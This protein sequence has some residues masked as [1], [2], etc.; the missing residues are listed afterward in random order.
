MRSIK[1]WW[2]IFALI[3]CTIPAFGQNSELTGA[4]SD[5]SGARI[6]SASVAFR[7]EGTNTTQRFQTNQA[8][9]Y[10]AAVAPGTYSIEI[11]A[12]GFKTVTR[13][14]VKLDVA[15]KATLDFSLTAGAEDQ[16]VTV[17]A[18]APILQTSSSVGNLISGAEIARLPVNGRNYTTLELLAPGVGD[19]SKSQN[20]GTISGTNLYSINGQR[21]QDHNYLLD[22]IEN[23]FFHKSSPGGSPPL[24]AI[25]EFQLATNNSAEYGRSAGAA[26]SLVSK[27]G[28][29]NFHGSLYEYLRN[30]A[31]DANNY[32]ANHEGLGRTPLHL[33]NF[34]VAVD[35]PLLG[36]NKLRGLHNTF[37]FL[38]YDGLRESQSNPI[39]STV[40][41][42][43]E[44]NGNFS[45][46]GASIYDPTTST[47][48][49]SG[50]VIR[51]KFANNMI[52]ASMIDPVATAYLKLVPLPNRSGITNNYVNTQPKTNSHD[53]WLGRVDYAVNDRNNVFFRVYDQ[54]V[55]QTSPQTFEDFSEVTQFNVINLGLGWTSQLSKDSVLQV[56]LGWDLPEGPDFT[57]NTL[58]VTG[59]QFLTQNNVQ[60]F[61][62]GTLYDFIPSISASGDF[63]ISESGGTSKDEVYQIS[64][65]YERQ[66]GRSDWKFGVSIVPRK[67][68]HASSSSLTGQASFTQGLTNSANDSKSGSS[69]ASFL[70]GYPSSVQR[71]QGN[72]VGNARQLYTAYYAQFHRR[73][74]D[75]LTLDA[76]VRYEFFP[77]I[78]DRDNRFG[79]LWVHT[80]P[81]TGAPVGTLLWAGV[82]PLPDQVTGVV[83]D[84][85]NRAG[86]GR[87]LQVTDYN[88]WAPRIGLAYSPR[89][90]WVIRA[91]AGVYYNTTFF[92]ESQDKSGFYPYNSQQNFTTN[93]SLLP[94]L[95]IE[96]AG[97]SYTNTAGIGG[98]AQ[99][100]NNRTPY[101]W[102]YN[103]FI[104]KALP[105]SITAKIGYVGSQNRKQIGYTYFNT[106]P[107]P[108]PGAVQPRRY[109][110]DY[111]DINKG[112]NAFSSNYNALQMQLRKRYTSGLEFSANYTYSKSL[113][114]QSSLAEFKTQNPF[115][116]LA[117][118]S[119]SS[120]DLTH[121]FN[122]SYVY[123]LPFGRG[124]QFGA[125]MPRLADAFLG[126]WSVQ[127]I[128]RLETGPPDNPTSGQDR[129][130]VGKSVQRPD[131]VGNVNHGPKTIQQWFDKSALVLPAQY[132][133]GS[134]GAYIVQAPAL[135]SWDI[136]LHKVFRIVESQTLAFRAEAFNF[137][138]LTNFSDPNTNLSSGGFG[139][140]TSTRIANRQ[141]QLSLRYMF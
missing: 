69:T 86:F 65:D 42:Q 34:G 37:F 32:F 117:D 121:I 21:P 5:S 110:P 84:P 14:H 100:P 29:S 31:F 9:F 52:P 46:L 95:K 25:A 129:A 122:I 102:Q 28:T 127:G 49:G 2:S 79:T 12:P 93:S 139:T 53:N 58:G 105:H 125:D 51:Q 120:F 94:D 62:L 92:Q 60:L 81:T 106:A 73:M 47:Y 124:R 71:G 54:S 99:D 36:L 98:Y 57:R 132:T 74:T 104:E 85:P 103:L 76:G 64:A 15:L 6:P 119:R 22:G 138:N 90:S 23:D 111:G 97:P 48:D 115:N 20:D 133:F 107:I 89:E 123:D 43:D 55:S 68:F 44:R 30:D 18:A 134:A 33:N 108:G 113:D 40:P 41:T 80:D 135:R 26:V 101:S 39:I 4:I 45:A 66:M 126:G 67:Y 130:N 96:D 61:S 88:N 118:Y 131:L 72:G 70:L 112:A 78:W 3:A 116:P 109:L 1:L 8:G 114:Y 140:I 75:K 77:P 87:A 56:H 63:S 10:F 59:S 35:G 11:S 83:G 50:K 136:S 24:D 27:S 141:L 16:T 7:D 128:T 91:G 13:T 137:P 19:I 82:N 38:N 17:T